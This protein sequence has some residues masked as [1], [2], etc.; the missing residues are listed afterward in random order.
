MRKRTLLSLVAVLLVLG[1]ACGSFGAGGGSSTGVD[2]TVTNRSPDE[3]CYVLISPSSSESWGDDQLADDETIAPG[4]S[5]TFSMDEDTHDVRAENCEEI[6]MA[7]AWEISKDTTVTV[8]ER[9][10]DTRL[11]IVNDSNTDVCYVFISRTT[12]DDW[13]E[14]WM[15]DMEQLVTGESRLFYVDGGL[16]D[17][18]A[19][20]CD[21]EPLA[22]EYE[23]DITEDLTW[24]L[25]DE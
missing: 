8:G 9:G 10:A 20:D 3:V 6:A 11:L 16:Y 5:R 12:A 1:L 4:D 15:G 25:Y 18:Q 7:T 13:G 2:I 24:T 22:E 23:V 19:A 17:L 14:D 21:G